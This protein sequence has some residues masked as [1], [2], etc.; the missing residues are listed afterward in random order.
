M[1]LFVSGS[2]DGG[3]ATTTVWHPL[4]SGWLAGAP[5]SIEDVQCGEDGGDGEEDPSS[6]E[7]EL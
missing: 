5:S 2:L 4:V 6:S 7:L 3:D 1:H